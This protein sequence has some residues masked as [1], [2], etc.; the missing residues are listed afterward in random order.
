MDVMLDDTLRQATAINRHSYSALQTIV[1]QMAAY[2]TWRSGMGTPIQG[3]AA[4][5]L[6]EKLFD[7]VSRTCV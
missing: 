5:H 6:A 7:M 3:D 1:L 4:H 2:R